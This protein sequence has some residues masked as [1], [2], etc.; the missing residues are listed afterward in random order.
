MDIALYHEDMGYYN[1]SKT[2]IGIEGDFYTSPDVHPFM[3]RVLA[4]M[5]YKMWRLLD[6]CV[7]T[8]L[9]MGAGKGR[10]ALDILNEVNGSYP[11]F[12]NKLSYV[13]IE[14]SQTF[15]VE[16]QVLLDNH[17]GK[18]KWYNAFN[19]LENGAEVVGCVL[20]NELIDAFPFHRICMVKDE[21]KEIYV[22]CKEG[23]FIE[24]IDDF[25]TPD[26]GDYI[27]KT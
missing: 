26:L 5:L 6:E 11:K 20:S 4:G 23:E 15:M 27:R 10:M 13:I 16:Q 22:S 3:G 18:V 8:I 17:T 12:Y 21:L 14:R 1:S 7:F 25:S 9:E 2:K 19:E 24:V